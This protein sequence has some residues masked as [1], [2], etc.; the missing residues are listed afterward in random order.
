MRQPSFPTESAHVNSADLRQRLVA[1]LAADAAGYSRLMAVDDRATVA[2]LDAARAVFHSRIE[3]N[4]GR[5]IDMAGDS[6]LAVFRT[7][8][9][10]VAAAMVVQQDLGASIDALPQDRRM[11]FRIGIHMGDVIEKADGTVYGDGVNIASRL[12]GVA[13][14]GGILVSD[15]VYGAVRDRIGEGFVDQGEQPMKNIS[16]PVHAFKLTRAAPMSLRA[17][18]LRLPDRP[19][20]AVLPFTNMSGD[21]EQEYFADG[22]TEDII[23]DCSKISGLFVIARNST[24]VYKKQS[25]DIQEVGRKLGVRHVLEGSVRRA[26]MRVRIN[27]QL[28]DAESGGHIWADRYDRE[29]EDIFLVQ[30]EVTR[31]IVETLEVRLTGN[32]EARRQE[33]GKV[34]GE[35]YDYL[36]RAK[37]CI[38]QF[39]APALV[40]TREMLERALAIDPSMALGYAYLAI[41]G[42]IEYA[43][44][45]N[46]RTA[47][48]LH[49]NLALAG[50]ACECD[51]LEPMAHH[52][53]SNALMWLRRLDEAESAARRSVALDP[54]SSQ[55]YGTLG[56]ILDFAGRHEEAIESLAK[57]LRLDPQFSLWL[58]AQGRAQF[59]I[60]RYAEAEAS[61]KRRLIHMPGSDVTRAY[62]ASLYG[63]TGRHEEAHQIWS[64]LMDIHPEYA[65]ELTLRVLPYSNPAPLEQFVAGLRKA[66]LTA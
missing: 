66:G 30:D 59:V 22:I 18:A 49:E 10:A 31:K 1:I 26:G 42:G 21:S 51:P 35:A 23:T 47:D 34:N 6:V 24:F 33:R 37:S 39:T 2:A 9:G 62:L 61:F 27:V 63:H 19:S 5:V 52:A 55:S 50:K 8:A 17:P 38:V 57:A 11:P 15:A 45:W 28:I 4:H 56:V 16:H 32:E 3:A 20:L 13:E 48:D 7:A 54:N 53:L 25:V 29:I 14:P 40:E 41:A 65:I 64:E 58:H 44:A 46:G 36:I 43:N 12:C 60:A